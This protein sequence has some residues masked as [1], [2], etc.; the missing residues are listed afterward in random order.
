MTIRP[1]RFGGTC[2]AFGLLICGVLFSSRAAAG[3]PPPVTGLVPDHAALSVENLEIEAAWYQRVLGFSR[4]SK[5]SSTPEYTNWHLVIP[6]YRIDLIKAK[7]STR[8]PVVEPTYLQQ[9]WVHVVFHVQDVAAAWKT[10]QALQIEPKVKKDPKGIP[11]Q[12]RFHDPEGNEVEIR[13][14][15]VL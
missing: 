2:S 12:L 7:G 6:G 13:R 8:P 10:L 4:L 11:I 5:T 1:G 9:G 3:N 14:D 15:K